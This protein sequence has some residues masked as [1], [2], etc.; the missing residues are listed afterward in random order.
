MWNTLAT[1]RRYAQFLFGRMDPSVGTPRTDKFPYFGQYTKNNDGVYSRREGR[2]AGS[3][4]PWNIVSLFVRMQPSISQESLRW[5]GASS[6]IL[7]SRVQLS[8]DGARFAAADVGLI[9]HAGAAGHKKRGIVGASVEGC[10]QQREKGTWSARRVRSYFL[11]DEGWR[12]ST[13]MI[14]SLRAHS[15]TGQIKSLRPCQFIYNFSRRIKN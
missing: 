12:R 6:T 7:V 9:S 3:R 1:A 14:A 11:S 15:K 13:R 8:V 5:R 4:L 2:D 10:N